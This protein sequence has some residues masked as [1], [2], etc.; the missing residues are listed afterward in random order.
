MLAVTLAS[1]AALAAAGVAAFAVYSWR[2]SGDDGPDEA[3]LARTFAD[4]LG[5]V[6]HARYVAL[7][8]ITEGLWRV[9]FPGKTSSDPHQCWAIHLHDFQ[10]LPSNE[11]LKGVGYLGPC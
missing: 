10:A 11:N 9:E 8:R 3:A 1:L 7:T 5:A 4:E 2:W 6:S